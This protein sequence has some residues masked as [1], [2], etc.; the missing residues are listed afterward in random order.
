[1]SPTEGRYVW[2]K[3]SLGG[4]AKLAVL[5]LGEE[6]ARQRWPLLI[7]RDG[8]SKRA[9][10]ASVPAPGVHDATSGRLCGGDRVPPAVESQKISAETVGNPAVNTPLMN[11]SF[12]ALFFQGQLRG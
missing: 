2:Q 7:D 9:G 6:C 12:I 4:R 10:A 3:R 1:M 8:E 11:S 5:R